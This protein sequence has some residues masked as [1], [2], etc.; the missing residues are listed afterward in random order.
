MGPIHTHIKRIGERAS[1][2]SRSHKRPVAATLVVTLVFTLVVATVVATPT[3]AGATAESQVRPFSMLALVPTQRDAL[4]L[5]ATRAGVHEGTIQE[6]AAR[7][8]GIAR[9]GTYVGRGS[10]GQTLISFFSPHRIA[11]FI[12]PSKV[13][14]TAHPL[15]VSVA[16]QPGADQGKTGHVQLSGVVGSNIRTLEIALADGSVVSANLVELG[17]EGY[18]FFTYVSDEPS[19]FPRI[20]RALDAAGAETSEDVSAAIRPP[21]IR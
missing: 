2:M 9:T 6:V 5:V 7:G 15:Y 16:A 11:G 21:S 19:S 3:R 14:S 18:S 4:V 13:T 17:P 10:R 12:P 20:V 8:E 1:K